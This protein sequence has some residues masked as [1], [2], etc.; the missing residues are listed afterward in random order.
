[1][2]T[3]LE[4]RFI[5]SSNKIMSP[6]YDKDPEAIYCMMNVMAASGTPGFEE[7]SVKIVQNWI[8]K[9]KAK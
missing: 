8:K 1:M 4:L 3:A 7:Y 2:G 5:K 9:Y 6:A